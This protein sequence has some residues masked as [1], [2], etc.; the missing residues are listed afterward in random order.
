MLC[1]LTLCHPLSPCSDLESCRKHVNETDASGIVTPHA[2]FMQRAIELSK[3][4]GLEKRTGEPCQ[5][6]GPA[7]VPPLVVLCVPCC[8]THGHTSHG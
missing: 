7:G 1:V 3:I 5:P 6:P 8:T 4:A 2:R